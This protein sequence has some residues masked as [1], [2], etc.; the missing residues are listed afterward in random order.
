V[1]LHVFQAMVFMLRNT[2]KINGQQHVMF[3]KIANINHTITKFAPVVP[4][5][6]ALMCTNFGKKRTSFAE[7]TL[8]NRMDPSSRTRA[9]LPSVLNLRRLWNKLKELNMWTT[10]DSRHSSH[11]ENDLIQ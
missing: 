8:K 6:C 1:I 5:T 9:W 4:Y 10:I 2:C 11:F 3:N 7:V